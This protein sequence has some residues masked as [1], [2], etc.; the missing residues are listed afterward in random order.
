TESARRRT[1]QEPAPF[2][3]WARL[4]RVLGWSGLCAGTRACGLGRAGLGLSR[5]L[6]CRRG[7]LGLGRGTWAG[8]ARAA[9]LAAGLFL[10]WGGLL[11]LGLVQARHQTRLAAG[12]VV[13]MD[14]ALT[15]RHIE[16]TDRLAHGLLGLGSRGVGGDGVARLG[17]VGARGGLDGV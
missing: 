2:P 5:W 6:G 3:K 12:G 11:D 16:L 8:D 1:P 10:D 9:H 13:A 14:D 15:G 17:D 4:L 7:D